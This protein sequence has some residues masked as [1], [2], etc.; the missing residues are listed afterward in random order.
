MKFERQIKFDHV[1][2]QKGFCALNLPGSQSQYW[3][4]TAC[5]TNDLGVIYFVHCLYQ[6][7]L[8]L[9][10]CVF[11]LIWQKVML[12]VTFLWRDYTVL[13]LELTCLIT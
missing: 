10:N 9:M 5:A 12:N 8:Y 1:F 11:Y 3:I 7:N 2:N 13:S 4:R 6:T